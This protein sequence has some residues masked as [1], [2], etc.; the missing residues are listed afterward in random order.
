MLSLLAR[1]YNPTQRGQHDDVDCF[2]V[3]V[4]FFLSDEYVWARYRTSAKII[5]GMEKKTTKKQQNAFSYFHAPTPPTGH[6]SQG[7]DTI[8]SNLTTDQRGTRTRTRISP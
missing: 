5:N 7:V 4:F 6:A 2:F 1:N 8:I 3:C